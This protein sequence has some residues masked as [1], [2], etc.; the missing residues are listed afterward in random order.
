MK[1]AKLS[2]NAEKTSLR[3]ADL[4]ADFTEDPRNANKGTERG[5]KMLDRSVSK[6]GLGRSILVDKNGVVI[7][8]NKMRQTAVEH[9]LTRAKVVEVS[10]DEMVVVKRVDLD[11]ME[12][13]GP[14]R[15]MAYA[16]NRVAEVDLDW[17]YAVI[18]Q[19]RNVSKEWFEEIR[20]DEDATGGIADG[21]AM[22]DDER[23]VISFSFE[24]NEAADI[25]ARLDAI[26]NDNGLESD[27]DV[28][29]LLLGTYEREAK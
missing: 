12:P 23:K 28:L 13:D 22:E 2:A 15:E 11:L 29:I 5:K 25:Q 16:D 17:D 19:D 4:A 7:A 10:G 14:A 24:A 18:E 6:L 1:N 3:L 8:G 27:E 9:G 26:K 20:M 21:D